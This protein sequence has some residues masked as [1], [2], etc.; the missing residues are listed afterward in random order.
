MSSVEVG[1]A[2]T[3]AHD[4]RL[5]S[6]DGKRDT[7]TRPA[8][9]L[10]LAK[11]TQQ[12]ESWDDDFETTTPSADSFLKVTSQIEKSQ[13]AIR[14][15]LRNLR[16]FAAAA[17][18]LKSVLSH[19]ADRSELHANGT[20][21]DEHDKLGVADQLLQEAEAIVALAENSDDLS[22]DVAQSQD[23]ILE[24][25]K[26]RR[27]AVG[28]S[29]LQELAILNSQKSGDDRRP[30]AVDQEVQSAQ[31]AGDDFDFAD[32][33][34]WEED[35]DEEPASPLRQRAAG[36]RSSNNSLK[37]NFSADAL[38]ALIQRTEKLIFELSTALHTDH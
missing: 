37:I 32:D 14:L 21:G 6:L 8:I 36:S 20:G 16:D 13:S 27:S 22:D 15:H 3:T 1:T 17:S 10:S 34:V 7:E 30:A 24:S 12:H 18:E 28:R 29:I 2:E 26:G 31:G 38:P 25:E 33:A 23:S 19:V 9:Q 11:P 4:E 5:Q 35:W